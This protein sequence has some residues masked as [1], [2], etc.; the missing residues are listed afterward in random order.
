[1]HDAIGDRGGKVGGKAGRGEDGCGW[2]P[3]VQFGNIGDR[4]SWPVSDTIFISQQWKLKGIILS[5][6]FFFLKNYFKRLDHFHF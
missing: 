5:F 6:N 1:M 2:E 3:S 4:G